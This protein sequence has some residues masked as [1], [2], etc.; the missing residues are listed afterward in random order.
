MAQSSGMRTETSKQRSCEL[1][2][3]PSFS[4]TEHGLTNEQNVIV[5]S[6]G[7]R[8]L[9]VLA[10]PGTGK[11]AVLSH[12]IIH[13]LKTKL[14]MKKEIIGIA[15]T[16]KAAK[17]MQDKLK[18]LGLPGEHQPPISTL[19]S[20]SARMLRDK[21]GKICIPDEFLIADDHESRLILKDAITDIWPQAM[22]YLKIWRHKISLLK[23]ERK[24]PD[25]ISNGLLKKVYARYQELLRFH[26]ALDFEDLIIEACTLLETNK[27]ARRNCQLRARYLF[28]DEF[29]DI[30]AAEYYL[31]R[32]LAG[33]PDGLFVVGDD[34]QSIYSWRGGNPKIILGFC[35]DFSG[36]VKKP[37]TICFRCPEKIIRGADAFIKRKPPLVA[38][39]SASDP[40]WI[41]NSKSDVQET[42]YITNWIVNALKSR[43]YLSKDIAI[44]YRGGDVADKAA[45][46]LT[47]ANIPIIRPSPEETIHLKEL[48][49]CL[50]LIIDKHD[51]L[52]LRVCLA[53]PLAR[54]IGER[55]IKKMRDFA[56]NN[57]CSFWDAF[58]TAQTN[59]SFKRWHKRL[60]SF[61]QIFEG[62]LVATSK[63]KI[64]ELLSE[65]AKSLSYR[66][67]KKINE[68]IKRSEC[69][70]ENWS[71]HNFVQ[72]IRGLKGEKAA[73]P[74]ESAEEENDAVLF[75]TTHSV[76]GLERK[77]IFVLGM[78]QGR[79]PRQ[80]GDM[81][82][83]RRLF[84]V[85]MT[86]AK[87]KLF[88]CYAKKREG[89]S[90]QGFEFY[91]RSSFIFEIPERYRE[92]ATPIT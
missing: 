64:S 28:V 39:C 82:E 40:I 85:A 30:N 92:C 41:I 70:P 60:K 76:K 74:K 91:R 1:I 11:T 24:R 8:P 81:D 33:N 80:D 27:E 21:G 71:L 23:A 58:I 42:R 66:N 14:A 7:R 73:D 63:K 50:R 65:I 25:N 4:H 53:S 61:S 47:K 10:G 88:L 29:Q 38:R 44:L 78:E 6:I 34:K 12:G 48:V 13:L 9:L 75:I 16:T 5:R 89:R 32:L 2:K 46:A 79:F 49:S 43:K 37:M 87:E 3:D 36:A 62:F 90:A 51:S 54:G 15:F 84:Y 55:A 26:L 35:N 68:I 69:I 77:V 45:D 86:R 22:K 56:E 19:H 20:L 17:S 57:G 72:D 83:Q 52:A 18:E 67:E 59:P 31:I